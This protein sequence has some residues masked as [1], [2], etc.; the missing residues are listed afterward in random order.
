MTRPSVDHT[1]CDDVDASAG[2][3]V[4]FAEP[5]AD[6]AGQLIEGGEAVISGDRR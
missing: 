4:V 5:G 6:K 3:A 2:V 1:I